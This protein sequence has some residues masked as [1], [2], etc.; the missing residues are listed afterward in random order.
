MVDS[1]L[2]KHE[3]NE[4]YAGGFIIKCLMVCARFLNYE[5]ALRLSEFLVK[6]IFGGSLLFSPDNTFRHG[7]HMHSN[8]RTLVGAVDYALN[9][10]DPVI[11]SR[12]D[13]LYRYV[14]SVSNR[15]GFLPEVIGRKGDVIACETCAI[16]DYL[17]LAVTLANHGHPE[18]WGDIERIAR[19]H[20]VESQVKDVSWL[21]S[22]PAREDTEQFTW[23]NIGERM[24]GGYAGWSSPNHI[25][26]CK[27]TLNAH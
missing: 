23:R 24:L 19:N 5:P 22:D 15:F 11:Y 13:A 27:E 25:L 26:A 16:M 4:G 9:A 21:Q 1:L 14:R 7:G 18:Y 20:L 3:R 12:A 2:E 10:K 8:L 17:G 6:G